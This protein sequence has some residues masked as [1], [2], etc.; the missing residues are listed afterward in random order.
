[1]KRFILLFCLAFFLVSFGSL[2]C[3]GQTE[4]KKVHLNHQFE[5]SVK[6]NPSTG[7]QWT[8]QFDAQFL[9][10]SSKEHARDSSKPKRFLGV[11]GMTTFVFMPTKVGKT[12]IKF[13]YMRPWEK[14]A[15]KTKDYVVEIS[16]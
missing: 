6:G 12:S 1:M 16:P 2:D 15:I 3:L 9:K 5:I 4:T 11:P 8:A 7:Y 10:L 13:I 14:K